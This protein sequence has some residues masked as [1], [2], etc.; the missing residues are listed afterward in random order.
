MPPQG[1]QR[2][3]PP[4]AWRTAE[5]F[6]GRLAGRE[7]SRQAAVGVPRSRTSAPSAN[8]WTDPLRS[9]RS[10]SGVRRHRA[11]SPSRA[12][13]LGPAP[14]PSP[15]S[16][17]PSGRARPCERRG[18]PAAAMARWRRRGASSSRRRPDTL[19]WPNAQASLASSRRDSTARGSTARAHC[20]RQR[21]W[22]ML[23]RWRACEHHPCTPGPSRAAQAEGA[24]LSVAAHRLRLGCAS[25]RDLLGEAVPVLLPL[26]RALEVDCPAEA[27]GVANGTEQ[28]ACAES[29]RQATEPKTRDRSPEATRP[30]TAHG[31][32]HRPACRAPPRATHLRFARS[33]A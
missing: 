7:C 28:R 20:D 3:Q 18:A 25:F 4:T 8:L 32:A 2:T 9:D 29:R 21:G 14:P 16:L 17:H 13:L 31:K 33:A 22:P 23:I 6:K 1:R 24:R 27:P 12:S 15:L 19:V 30:A 11:R 10:A 26:L 5:S